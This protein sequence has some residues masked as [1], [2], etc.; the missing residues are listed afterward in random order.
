MEANAEKL[1]FEDESINQYTIAFGL[2]NVTNI[3]IALR[4]AYRVLKKGG[5]I[6]ILEFS[7][8]WRTSL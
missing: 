3:D 8:T 1:P 5:R 4:E 2:R 6:S 7:Q